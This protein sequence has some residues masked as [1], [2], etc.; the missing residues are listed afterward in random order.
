MKREELN[1]KSST[2]NQKLQVERERIAAQT[3]ISNNQLNIAIQNKNKYDV[4]K[5]KDK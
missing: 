5:P 3:Q 4:K 1:S 2:E